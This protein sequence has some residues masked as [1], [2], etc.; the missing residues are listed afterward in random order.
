MVSP[1]QPLSLQKLESFS[2]KHFVCVCVC[3][4]VPV[5]DQ[6]VSL[7]AASW[8][9][10]YQIL[11]YLNFYCGA[12][13]ASC[14]IHHFMLWV[15]CM[16]IVNSGNQSAALFRRYWYINLAVPTNQLLCSD[17]THITW[18]LLCICKPSADLVVSNEACVMLATVAVSQVDS[19]HRQ[20]MQVLA[21]VDLCRTHHIHVQWWEHN[22]ASDTGTN[23]YVFC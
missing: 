3:V 11:G 1:E 12:V 4:C 9:F 21:E 22:T 13:E 7:L 17:T 5:L 10:S 6:T 8:G 20:V 16:N 23:T 15:L 2:A 18:W 14:T 19:W